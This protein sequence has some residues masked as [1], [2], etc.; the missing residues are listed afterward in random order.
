MFGGFTACAGACA[1]GW[2]WRLSGL[3]LAALRLAACG[4][5]GKIKAAGGASFC[6]GWLWLSPLRLDG[7]RVGCGCVP[8]LGV[9]VCGVGW[10]A[11]MR[12]GVGAHS[13]PVFASSADDCGTLCA[14]LSG[15]GPS[16]R[17]A[18]SARSARMAALSAANS[19]ASSA[20]PATV[21]GCALY[22]LPRL[23]ASSLSL[24]ALMGCIC[25]LLLCC[26]FRQ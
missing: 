24:Q 17:S 15:L 5:H 8:V 11:G 9:W 16:A 25:R 7:L 4:L 14:A 3:V 20:M 12:W 19:A 6:R 1:R 21:A 23:W 26:R 22:E 13:L 10:A 2:F 18:C